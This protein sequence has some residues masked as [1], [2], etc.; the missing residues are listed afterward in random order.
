MI[1]WITRLRHKAF[2]MDLTSLPEADRIEIKKSFEKER[3][4][5]TKPTDK[6]RLLRFLKR[7]GTPYRVYKD[8]VFLIAD[9]LK[10]GAV[11][12]VSVGDV[13]DFA[14][15][16][17]GKLIGTFTQAANSFLKTKGDRNA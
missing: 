7:T 14:F 2:K 10:H 17:N 13:F 16:A 3:Q 15:D 1:D 12:S 11:E 9:A 8:P 5:K 4:K 6:R